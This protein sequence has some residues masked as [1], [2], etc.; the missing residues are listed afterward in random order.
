MSNTSLHH[1]VPQSLGGSNE[2]I[3]KIILPEQ[4]HS[5]WHYWA[6]NLAPTAA[7]RFMVLM[8]IGWQEGSLHPH[9]VKEYFRNSLK[10]TL[11]ELY[12]ESSLS[13]VTNLYG[14]SKAI[15]NA[16][17]QI[18][19][20]QI[21]RRIVIANQQALQGKVDFPAH[22][23]AQYP[24]LFL[25][26]FETGKPYEALRRLFTQREEGN[27]AWV[28]P[29]KKRVRKKIMSQLHRK[30]STQWVPIKSE[31]DKLYAALET[32]KGQLSS[33]EQQWRTALY[34]FDENPEIE[35]PSML[36][37]IQKILDENAIPMNPIAQSS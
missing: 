21:E 34:D 6:G 32:H 22:L 31:K 20:L 7:A 9:F 35:A 26:F 18:T 2:D 19:H 25:E 5:D 11:D 36:W 12:E 33:K 17:H 29:L 28:Q 24:A 27:L 10:T 14:V 16:K 23:V 3:N 4:M 15:S 30:E 8:S 37:N 1:Q 13:R